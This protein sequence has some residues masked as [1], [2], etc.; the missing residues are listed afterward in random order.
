MAAQKN[1]RIL[2]IEDEEFDVIRVKRTLKPFATSIEIVDY[3]AD[4]VAALELLRAAPRCCDVVIMDFQIAGGL[5]GENLIRKIK[6]IDA[7][8]Q[9]I[10]I[11][12]MTVNVTDFEFANGLLKAGA[13]WY[14]TKYPVDME[15]FIY[16][17][18]DFVMSVFNA[19]E[20]GEL[21]RS[22]VRSE[23]KIDKNIS[24]IL[25][26]KKIIGASTATTTLLQQIDK[27]STRD[28]NVLITGASGTGKELIANNIHYN[29]PRKLENFV[30]INCGSI[31]ADLIESE[32]FG[33]VKGA[34]TGA[35]TEKMG[36]FEL[37]HNGTVFLDEVAELPHAAQVKL[38][39]VIQEGE[40][41]KIGRQ[42]K[43][44]VDVRI[45]AATNK[46]L[47]KEV[48][49]KRF[50]EDLYYRLS[51]VPINVLP[52]K[53]RRDDIPELIN[54]YLAEYC[55]DMNRFQPVISDDA[56]AMLCSYDWP[57]NVRELKNVIQRLLFNDERIFSVINILNALGVVNIESSPNQNQLAELFQ[58]DRS[59]TL[60]Q[61]EQIFREKYLLFVREH[62][63]SDADAAQKLGVAPSNYSRM[64]KDLGLK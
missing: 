22:R 61:A 26:Q 38:L 2:L 18:T 30:P 7:S 54:Y 48:A 52:L 19:F 46:D 62:S 4:G 64:V 60:K 59:L 11:T 58:R 53:E 37:A 3:C 56:L 9:I 44:F 42:K 1:I 27:Y 40:V 36:L 57:G 23:K 49:E 17:P 63:H 8:L 29:G 45:I 50:R 51:V 14:C 20:K 15:N 34:F 28:I 12:K 16:Q 13:F 41:E 43:I 25:T 35:N 10:V 47:R 24:D 32:L 33:Y 6:E 21:E 31:P 39:R 55:R 5:M